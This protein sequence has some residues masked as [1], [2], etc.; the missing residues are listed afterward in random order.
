MTDREKMEALLK[1]ETLISGNGHYQAV[2]T[3]NGKLVVG[4][5]SYRGMS[6]EDSA[7]ILFKEGS[8]W[9]IKLKEATI[10]R[11]DLAKA[12]SRPTFEGAC[13]ELG[14]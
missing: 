5:N 7:D 10:T 13:K 4:E 11:D 2:L 14:L 3:D 8:S 9:H 1:G 12:L 6:E